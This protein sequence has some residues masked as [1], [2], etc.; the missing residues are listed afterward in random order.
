MMKATTRLELIL[1]GLALMLFGIATLIQAQVPSTTTAVT[2]TSVTA[3][4]PGVRGGPAGAGGPINGLTARQF[5]FFTDGKADF[6]EVEAVAEGLGPRMNL[7]SCAGCHA[8]PATGGTSPF[9]NPQVAF[10]SKDGG[11]DRVPFFMTLNGPVREARFKFNP[12]GTRDG[13][14]HNT[15]TI[16]GRTGTAGCVL[17]QPDFDT[18]AAK[19]NLIFRIPTPLF[20]AGLIEQIPDTVIMANQ[21]ANRTSKQQLGIGGHPNL[22]V[23][24]RAI[25]GRMN[26]NGNDGTIAR[27][28]WKAQNQTLLL[29]SGEAYNVEMG[30]TNELFQQEREQ[31][32][33]CQFATLPNDV[34]DTEIATTP[35]GLNAIEKFAFFQR[36]LAPP[37][38]SPDTPGGASSI[39]NG[40]S[41]F[42]STGCALCHTPTLMTGNSTVTA[43]RYQS[44]NLFSDLLLHAMGPG[45]A[46]NIFQGGARGDEFRSAPLWGLGQR[47]FLLHDGRTTDLLQ[48]IQAHMSAG[49]STF[50][51]SEANA[52]TD[53]FNKLSEKKKQDLMNFLRSL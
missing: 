33:N 49:D 6:E 47:I 25:T 18:Q 35:T 44:V 21:A 10:A 16:T 27:F 1:F 4:D 31:N 30:I 24:G 36:F 41:L 38:S 52:V 26:N 50:G 5:E 43:L 3:R 20:G 40:R 13:G 37:T 46:D 32:P 42:V 48:A 19:N 28:G 39:S 9:V 2:S 12:D 34:T 45:L 14:V 51:P 23:S 15:A 17:A 11:T 8:Q 22:F 29:F 7:D 53:N